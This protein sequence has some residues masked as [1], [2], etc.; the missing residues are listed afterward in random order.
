MGPTGPDLSAQVLED[1]F[2]LYGPTIVSYY[3]ALHNAGSPPLWN[4]ATPRRLIA[5]TTGSDLIDYKVESSGGS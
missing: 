2:T 1:S 4:P 5:S 3:S